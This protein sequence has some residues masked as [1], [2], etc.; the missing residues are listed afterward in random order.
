MNK[1]FEKLNLSIFKTPKSDGHAK[2]RSLLPIRDS[3]LPKSNVKNDQRM[4]DVI[5][6]VV[7]AE[8]KTQA[9][10]TIIVYLF[11]KVRKKRLT[12]DP[13]PKLYFSV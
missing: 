2:V 13:S 3:M 11:D 8:R 12:N 5:S 1:K 10:G 7:L 6:N 4:H 9:V